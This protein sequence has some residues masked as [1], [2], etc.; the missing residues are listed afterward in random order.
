MS[1][2]KREQWQVMDLS[3]GDDA[4][5][6]SLSSQEIEWDGSSPG[7]TINGLFDCYSL[8]MAESCNL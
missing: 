8:K 6:V 2:S 3:V 1:G 4:Y 5:A 7:L